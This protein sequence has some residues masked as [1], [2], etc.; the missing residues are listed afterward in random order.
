MPDNGN[1][2]GNL[3]GDLGVAGAQALLGSPNPGA[4][5]SQDH[6]HVGDRAWDGL[7]G[8]IAIGGGGQEFYEDHVAAD[9][10]ARGLDETFN[11]AITTGGSQAIVAFTNSA[12]E[13]VSVDQALEFLEQVQCHVEGGGV[14]VLPGNFFPSEVGSDPRVEAALEES[15]AIITQPLYH[16]PNGGTLSN[17]QT[18]T[19]LNAERAVQA[20]QAMAGD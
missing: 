10:L 20:A 3:W 4:C 7:M 14:V 5:F 12:P 18:V 19:V 15:G 16:N 11:N 17:G 1:E 13:Q 2:V 8:I 6:G 9:N